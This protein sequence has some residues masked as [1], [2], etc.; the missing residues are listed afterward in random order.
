[1]ILRPLYLMVA[2]ALCA[3]GAET[4]APG[5]PAGHAVADP[6]GAV[7]VRP[8]V[9]IPDRRGRMPA[10]ERAIPTAPRGGAGIGRSGGIA[11]PTPA[12]PVPARKRRD[13]RDAPVS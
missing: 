1:M 10:A 7:Q 5:L 3:C 8:K 13:P 4:R 2:L 11:P 12:R 9:L 6:G